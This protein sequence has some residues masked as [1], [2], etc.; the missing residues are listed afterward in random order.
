M[1]QLAATSGIAVEDWINGIDDELG[2]ILG[3]IF[4]VHVSE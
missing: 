4:I 1:R 3:A 2:V